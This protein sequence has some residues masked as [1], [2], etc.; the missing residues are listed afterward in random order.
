LDLVRPAEGLKTDNAMHL[1]DRLGDVET[2]RRNRL[3]DLAPPNRGA[4]AGTHIHG[5]HV[6]VEE[7]STA[8]IPDIRERTFNARNLNREDFSNRQGTLVW[9]RTSPSE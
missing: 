8:S 2:D 9:S 3:H 5:T 1:E 7:P 6:P 4:S